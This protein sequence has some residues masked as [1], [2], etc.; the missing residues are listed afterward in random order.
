MAQIALIIMLLFVF[1]FSFQRFKLYTFESDNLFLFDFTWIKQHLFEIGGVNLIFTSFLTQFFKFPIV[2]AIITTIVY[3]SIIYC[4]VK[5][6]KKVTKNLNFGIISLLPI[7]F[8]MLCVEEPFYSF[9]G[10]VSLAIC[11]IITFVY[12]NNRAL[13]AKFDAIF[14]SLFA[15][16]IYVLFGSVAWLFA[17]LIIVNSICQHKF[18]TNGI[19]A[20]IALFVCCTISYLCENF[21]SI[22]EA[23]SPLQYYNW[24]TSYLI[25]TCAWFSVILA[26]IVLIFA[27]KLNNKY[28]KSV[29]LA[30]MIVAFGFALSKIHKPDVA[31]MQHESYLADNNCWNEIIKLNK[32][33]PTKTKL[34]SYINLALAKQNL[35]LDRMFEFNQQLPTQR[36]DSRIVRNE[37]LRMESLVYFES[38]HL[39]QARKAAFNSV[40]ITTGGIEPHDVLR[41]IPINIAMG[42]KN[43]AQRYADALSKTL[44]YSESA[45]CALTD[46][47]KILPSKSNFC[48]LYGF[49]NDYREIV[50]TDTQNVVAQQFYIA[51]ILLSAD[52]EKLRNYIETTKNA[53]LHKRVQEAC[54]IMFTTDECRQMGVT[55]KV[56]N[57]FEALKKGEKIADFYRTYWYYIAYLNT[58]LKKQ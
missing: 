10:H 3:I 54:T 7:G 27:N 20:L 49:A 31:K 29:T 13:F 47:N 50:E 21:V 28:I 11:L 41:L 46:T 4:V 42:T 44:F 23:A 38:G 24:P 40:L 2:G 15:L 55:E 12:L 14:A 58:T 45:K 56:I 36:T 43:V 37:I 52:K 26:I 8:L 30:V 19:I 48:E 18:P 57:E 17:I 5:I 39:A 9:R 1:T 33:K 34:I 25:T 22:E 35:L 51:F 32:R 53:N 16:L 6:A